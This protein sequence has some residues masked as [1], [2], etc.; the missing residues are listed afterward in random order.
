MN[1]L[2]ANTLFC[3][4]FIFF[5]IIIIITIILSIL[6]FN[7]DDT[8]HVEEANC[9]GA[10]LCLYSCLI[11]DIRHHMDGEDLLILVLPVDDEGQVGGGVPLQQ[12][13]GV[14]G[15]NNGRVCERLP[16]NVPRIRHDFQRR[17][18]LTKLPESGATG[19]GGGINVQIF[20]LTF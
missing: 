8:S 17:D 10:E 19:A 4:Q 5:I 13:R 14:L 16:R 3:H 15:V 12:I 2:G 11:H 18:C 9:L 1:S 6:C 7:S 20:I